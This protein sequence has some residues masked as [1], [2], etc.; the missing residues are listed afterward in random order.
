VSKLNKE[1]EKGGIG[2]VNH[3]F[4]LYLRLICE[5]QTFFKKVRVSPP[6]GIKVFG[7]YGMLGQKL[8]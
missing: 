6:G 3:D 4:I 7:K 8:K 2:G 1:N 5:F